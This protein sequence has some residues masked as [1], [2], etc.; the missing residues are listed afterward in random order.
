MAEQN[1][2]N[3]NTPNPLLV[4]EGG[5]NIVTV[6]QGDILYG[7]GTNVYSRLPKVSLASRYLSNTGTDNNP[8]WAQ[9]NL[10]NGVTGN[11][12]VTNFNLGTDAS[13]AK[14]WRGDGTWADPI[15]PGNDL[16]FLQSSSLFV[17][18]SVNFINLTNVYSAYLI[19][20]S[21]FQNSGSTGRLGLRFSTN[22]GSSYISSGYQYINMVQN[23]SS[24]YASDS[25]A[26]A[27]QIQMSGT[28]LL[29]SGTANSSLQL[30]LYNPTGTSLVKLTNHIFMNGIGGLPNVTIGTGI[31]ETASPVNA[32]RLF[33]TAGSFIGGTAKLYGAL[34]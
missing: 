6:A 34:A 33:M 2:I 19:V 5:T 23:G 10:A 16:I 11:L 4:P 32:I 29:D 8:A 25:S 24:A 3:L 26:S 17:N 21:N 7:S 22:N 30:W 1:C 20:I 14:F 27:G 18:T 9:V 31:Y 15:A 28:T 13:D 12:P